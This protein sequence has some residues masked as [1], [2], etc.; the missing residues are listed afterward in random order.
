MRILQ[1]FASL[2]VG[3][4]ETRMM[5][6]FR[7]IDREKFS[8]DFLTMSL[9]EQYYESEIKELGG[10][11]IKIAPPREKGAFGNLKDIINVLKTNGSYDAVHAHTS[12]HCGVV[13]LAAKICGV[14]V[15]ISHARTTGSKRRSFASKISLALGR[16][17]ISMFATHRLAISSEAGAYLF[18]ENSINK[19]N[20]LVMPNAVESEKLLLV[21]FE[22]VEKLKMQYLK[23]GAYPVLGHIGRFEEM[24]NHT[25]ILEIFDQFVKTNPNAFLILIGTGRLQ[26]QIE[27]LA[28][29]KNLMKN[30]LFAGLR[31]D[32]SNWL[33]IF[34]VFIMPSIFEG[35]GGAAIEAQIAGIPCV[36]SSAMPKEVDMQMG[37]VKF[38]PLLDD[39][40]TWCKAVTEQLSC[41]IPTI[42]QRRQI[43]NELGYSIDNAVKTLSEIY[44]GDLK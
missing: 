16:R 29:E 10:K 7:N 27:Q 9:E 35:L 38:L 24:K 18:G 22:L 28:I 5:D 33:P 15:R 40:E 34:N 36:L 39:K 30:I 17:F 23:A 11:I 41:N 2:N 8:F 6:V 4:A 13:M 25:F 44:F 31:R 1:V 32:I 19:G 26:P 3:G 21:D 20:V 42:Q 14:S 37:L 12:H 43:T